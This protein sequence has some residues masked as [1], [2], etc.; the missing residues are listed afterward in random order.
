MI[1]NFLDS[2]SITH[3]ESTI[4]MVCDEESRG[5]THLILQYQYDV[6]KNKLIGL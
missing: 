5:D 3:T 1:P 2:T 4:A 6:D